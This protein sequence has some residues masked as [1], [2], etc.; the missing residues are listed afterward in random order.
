MVILI[1]QAT[2]GHDFAWAV[3]FVGAGHLAPGFAI[4]V[5][6]RAVARAGIEVEVLASGDFL[7]PSTSLRIS[8]V[9]SDARKTPQR[10]RRPRE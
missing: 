7:D 9:G 10:T 3:F 4:L 1:I 6:G 8:A 2:H 5:P